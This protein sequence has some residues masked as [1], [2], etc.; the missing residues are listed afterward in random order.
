MAPA[1]TVE[2]QLLA[3]A[4]SPPATILVILSGMLEKLL[5]VMG[6]AGLVLFTG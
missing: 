2:P 4:N 3:S 6:A 5:S 1:A